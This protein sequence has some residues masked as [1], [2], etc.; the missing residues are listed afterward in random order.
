MSRVAIVTD[1]VASMPRELIKE[2][3]IR[4]V[5]M[6]LII[7]GK[8]Y[9]DQVDIHPDEFWARFKTIKK[10]TS[11]APTPGDFVNAFKEALRESDSIVCVV[12]SK[13][14]SATYQSAIQAREIMWIENSQLK[15][16]IIDSKG[17]TGSEG[18][19]AMEGAR[20]AQAGKTLPEVIQVMQDIIGRVRSVAGLETLKYLIRSGRAPKTA[21][22]G[23]LL[24]VKPIVGGVTGSGLVENLGT[25]KGKRKCFERL[26]EMVGEY[27]D[28]TKPLHVMVHYTTNIE[29]GEKLLEMVRVKYN[30]IESHLTCQSPL[31]G[32]HTGPINVICFYS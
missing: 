23:E 3:G 19:V 21:Y 6:G 24:G 9:R 26:V 27:T 25:A 8:S 14:L 11:S 31:S 29:D 1:S 17:Y 5:P 13:L 16:E 4:V 10:F 2:L 12:I 15:I 22:L 20:A 28:T 7:D 30:C 32:A 18:F